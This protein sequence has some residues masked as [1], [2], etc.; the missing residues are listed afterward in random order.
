[1]GALIALDYVLDG[2]EVQPDLLVTSAPP[3]TESLASWQRALIK[4]LARTIPRL[5]I[6]VPVPTD[7]LS[8]D[9]EIGRAYLADPLI[10]RKAALGSFVPYFEAQE[11]A[12]GTLEH[13]TLP[14]LVVHGGED[15]IVPTECTAPMAAVPGVQRIVYPGLRHELHNEPQGEQVLADT[16]AWM[17]DQIGRASR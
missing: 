8:T 3:L 10:Q 11:R 7:E 6:P 17:S 1:M 16:V 14:T 5:R 13:L 12:K 4:L 9:P 15:R 2:A